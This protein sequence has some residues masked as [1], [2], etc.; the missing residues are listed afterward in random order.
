[1][2]SAI[3]VRENS[4]VMRSLYISIPSQDRKRPYRA[5]MAMIATLS[6]TWIARTDCHTGPSYRSIASS[7]SGP[8]FLRSEQAITSNR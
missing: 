3:A 2:F 1:M 6:G 4:G 5:D 7:Q 8:A